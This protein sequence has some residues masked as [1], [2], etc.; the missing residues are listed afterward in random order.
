M[1]CEYEEGEYSVTLRARSTYEDNAGSEIEVPVVMG[2]AG[3]P[4][5]PNQLALLGNTPNPFNPTTTIRFTVPTG[6]TQVY[7]LRVY[8]VR[9][10]LVRDLAAGQITSGLHSV[11]WDGRNNSGSTVG[12]GI[13]LYR[14]EVG[15]ERFTG[16]MALV[17]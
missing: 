14:L 17:K 15:Q 2:S 5:S 8:D 9:G 12:S 1:G 7:S 3:G 11:L 16:K 6:P 10:R 4:V 13:Y